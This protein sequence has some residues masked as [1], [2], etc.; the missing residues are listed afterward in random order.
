LAGVPGVE[1]VVST[2]NGPQ[3]CATQVPLLSLPR[4]F[5]AK[6]QALPAEAP[7]L[8]APRDPVW[9]AEGVDPRSHKVGLVWSGRRLPDPKRS[10]PLEE[11]APLA[12][13]QGVV[14][15][16]LKPDLPDREL[17]AL[18][19]LIDLRAVGGRGHDFGE[20]ARVIHAL[21]LVISVDTAVAHLAGAIGKPVWT[22][23]RHAPEWRWGVAGEHCPWY[24]TMR[25][26]RQRQ[27]GAWRPVLAEVAR[28]LNHLAMA[29]T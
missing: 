26:I 1:A 27:P 2:G 18:G 22:L 17:E 11:L 6:S 21:D 3:G 29:R 25:L 8:R 5:R 10:V 13:V 24:P 28:D 12:D 9:A 15:F 16:S 7:Y 19:R 4:L 14:F 23:L 20:T